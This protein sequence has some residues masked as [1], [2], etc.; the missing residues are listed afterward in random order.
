[1]VSMENVLKRPRK[2]RTIEL[3]AIRIAFGVAVFLL[4]AGLFGLF[5]LNLAIKRGEKVTVSN[6]VNK[7]VVDALDILS[8][9]DLEL[10]K[11][12]ARNS[13]VIPENYVLS[14][15]PIPGSVVKEGTSVS[16]VISLGSRISLVPDLVGKSLREASVD[17]KRAGLRIGRSSMM[18]H[19]NSEDTV[20]AQSPPAGQQVERET[21]VSMLLSLGPR[22][23]EYRLPNLVGIPLERA[24]KLL[25]ALGISVGSITAKVDLTQ[26]QGMILDQDPRPGSL[27]VEGSSVSL[28]MTTLH[29]EGI[30]VER[31]FAVLL[32]S[33]PYA[34]WP[35]AVRI[36]VTDPD[37]SRVI[38]DEV[39]EPG[40]SI[41]TGFG[42][43]AQCTVKVY[44]DGTLE[45]ERIFR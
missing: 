33:V 19:Q 34:F 20:L 36:E 40:A 42:Y 45:M 44:L 13:S 7:S 6:V 38:Y 2:R 14:Q 8:E 22:P 41:A 10:R 37:G 17:L 9:R 24:G 15:D 28:V 1:M 5:S 21:P 30:G 23:R 43:S 11:T 25:E 32:Y 3:P 39:D 16:V 26:P 12:D 18:H 35:K 31:K 4:S 29:T 27:I